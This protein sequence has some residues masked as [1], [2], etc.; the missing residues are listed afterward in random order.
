MPVRTSDNQVEIG[1]ITV[2]TAG[3]MSVHPLLSPA[4]DFAQIYRAAM[5]VSWDP[6]SKCLITP[7]PRQWTRAD[8]FK[9]VV[10]AVQSEYGVQLYVS[11]KT[12]FVNFSPEDRREIELCAGASR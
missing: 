6:K 1:E 3:G 11:P 4:E 5:E 2:D 9:Q 7:P 12:R 10:R 8:W